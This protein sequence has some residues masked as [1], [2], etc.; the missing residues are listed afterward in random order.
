MSD[1]LPDLLVI[2]LG[3]PLCG[4]DGAGLLTARYLQAKGFAAIAYE[5]DASGLLNLLPGAA[6]VIVVDAA[7]SGVEAGTIHFLEASSDPVPESLLRCSSHH[8]GLNEVIGVARALGTLPERFDVYAIEGSQLA[9]G[10][11]MS[12]A[13]HAAVQMTAS[14]IAKDRVVSR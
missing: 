6:H 1:S 8:M 9:P 7:S 13:V 2:G 14:R 11:T 12:E 3:N 4:D 10:D 5:G